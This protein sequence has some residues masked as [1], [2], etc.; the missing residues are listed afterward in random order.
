M[1]DAPTHTPAT[2][3]MSRPWV[4]NPV[5][6]NI[7]AD[8]QIAYPLLL[9]FLYLVAFTV[10]SVRSARHDHDAVPQEPQQLGP[11]GK[12]LPNKKSATRDADDYY[13]LDFSK[14]RKLLFQW[15]SVGVLASFLGNIVVVLTHTLWERAE[16]YWCG[17]APTV[18]GPADPPPPH[19]HTDVASY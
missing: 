2:M 1:P 14:P 15:L 17:Q 16:R 11:G 13:D 10:R 19:D 6:Q 4:S 5:A 8:F 3:R 12:P 7:L 9:I 18:R